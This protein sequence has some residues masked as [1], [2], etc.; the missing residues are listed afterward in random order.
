MALSTYLK[1]KTS[2]QIYKL[3]SGGYYQ[4][5]AGDTGGAAP[6]ETNGI[7]DYYGATAK[8]ETDPYYDTQA[9]SAT[10]KSAKDMTTTSDRLKALYSDRGMGNSTFYTGADQSNTE[11]IRRGLRDNMAGIE[12]SRRGA[13][14]AK[15]ARYEDSQRSGEQRDEDMRIAAERA[16]AE[17]AQREQEARWRAE[18]QER[19]RVMAE[20]QLQTARA[21]AATKSSGGGSGT[22]A[23]DKLLAAFQKDIGSG[24]G[25]KKVAIHG[26]ERGDGGYQTREA[27]INKL[28][29]KYSGKIDPDDIA[30]YVYE[31]YAG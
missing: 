14:D 4:K 12:N 22:S 27:L 23:E 31:Y 8:A 28:R 7:A 25:N 11:D 2:G 1:D 17:Q 30:R 20:L 5:Y 6:T 29:T 3:G 9:A 13:Y 21:S 10:E 26:E 15:L 18:E 19:E 24:M 16:A